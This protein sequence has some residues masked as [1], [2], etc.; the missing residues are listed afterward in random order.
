MK[1]ETVIISRS[2]I[3]TPAGFK[4]VN[5]A[6][7]AICWDV[8]NCGELQESRNGETREVHGA[9]YT[10]DSMEN[11]FLTIHGRPIN[12]P[13]ALAEIIW[14]MSGS[15]DTWITE[16]NKKLK[17]YVDNGKINAA[18]GNRMRNAFG[19]D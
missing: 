6:Y 10:V 3:L 11:Y 1:Q 2:S 17:D 7:K 15:N 18:Y 16:Y 19:I 4:D 9:S 8:M 5:Q 12:F 14:I 13:M